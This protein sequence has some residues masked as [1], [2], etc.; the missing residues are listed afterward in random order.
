MIPFNFHHL[1]YFYT[2]AKAES[3]SKAAKE[4]RVSQPALSYQLKQFENYLG[5]PLFERRGRK[6]VL[7]EEGHLALKYAK[8]IFDLGKEFADSL[9]DRSQKGRIRIQIGVLNS[10]PKSTVSNLL[11]LILSLEPT[12]HIQLREDTLER[13]IVNLKDHLLDVVLADVPFQASSEDEITSRLAAK[14]PIVFCAHPKLAQKYKKIPQDLENAPMIFPTADSR[15]FHSVQEYMA[16]HGITPKIVAEVQD[17]EL[18]RLMA[19][20]GLGIVPLN[21]RMAAGTGKQKLKILNPPSKSKIHDSLYI[22]SKKRKNP[23]PLLA[24]IIKEFT[25]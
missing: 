9:S 1:Y 23:H 18:A 22:I 4:L 24:E 14:T 19:L 2:I 13:M 20:E 7:T 8:Q 3:V 21:A 15:T 16:S 25:L 10:I 12:A 17:I 11:K 6:L 5:V